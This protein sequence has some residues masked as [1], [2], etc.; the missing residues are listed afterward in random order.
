[1]SKGK[2]K[3]AINDRDFHA[4]TLGVI[5]SGQKCIAEV[6]YW[7]KAKC[8]PPP[9]GRRE[10]QSQ[11]ELAKIGIRY[12]PWDNSKH[13]VPLLRPTSHSLDSFI[14]SIVMNQSRD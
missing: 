13:I 14:N 11:R 10:K 1:M 7:S 9:R 2:L 3:F 6:I 4:W 8:S 5:G 12:I